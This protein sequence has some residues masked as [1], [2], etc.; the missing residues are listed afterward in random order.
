M[1][2]EKKLFGS[3]Q[4]ERLLKLGHCCVWAG[5]IALHAAASTDGSERQRKEKVDEALFSANSNRAV[6]Q[7]STVQYVLAIFIYRHHPIHRLNHDPLRTT[8]NSDY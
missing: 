3:Q 7:Y 6:Q 2:L 1:L 5:G 8:L 4:A